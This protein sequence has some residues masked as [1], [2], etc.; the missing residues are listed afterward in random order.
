M[1]LILHQVGAKFHRNKKIRDPQVP[2]FDQCVLCIYNGLE[3]AI[4]M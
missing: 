4:Q 1:S 2:D 3:I